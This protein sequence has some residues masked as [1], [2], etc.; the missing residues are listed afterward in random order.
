MVAFLIQCNPNIWKARACQFILGTTFDIEIF[1]PNFLYNFSNS[2]LLL[3]A[4]KDLFSKLMK[5]NTMLQEPFSNINH[6]FFSPSYTFGRHTVIFLNL[7][8]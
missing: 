1:K 4:L 6:C 3:T 7:R 8:N 2:G 5:K